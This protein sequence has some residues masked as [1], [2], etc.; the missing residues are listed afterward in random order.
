[1]ELGKIS[2]K[3][4]TGI[5]PDRVKKVMISTNISGNKLAN[6]DF[7]LKYSLAEGIQDWV[8]DCNGKLA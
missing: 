2:G 3:E 7:E 1:M 8:N 6:S 5:H 4:F